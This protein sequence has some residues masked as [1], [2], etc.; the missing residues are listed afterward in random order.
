MLISGLKWSL[1]KGENI[2]IQDKLNIAKSKN[3][4]TTNAN[5]EEIVYFCPFCHNIRIKSGLLTNYR[6]NRCESYIVPVISKK[7]YGKKNEQQKKQIIKD[8]KS[9][10]PEVATP[11][12][13]LLKKLIDSTNSLNKSIT[14]INRV[15]TFFFILTIINI[16]IILLSN[17]R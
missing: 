15:L 12:E 1:N 6:C 9:R 2:M 14:S 16:I 4:N 11:T 5:I 13:I 3:Q 17:V 7:D 10:Y 8:Y